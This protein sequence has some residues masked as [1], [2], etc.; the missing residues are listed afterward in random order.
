MNSQMCYPDG[1]ITDVTAIYV[2]FLTLQGTGHG[3][4]LLTIKAE[5]P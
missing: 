3:L 1:K 4:G 5:I 2:R